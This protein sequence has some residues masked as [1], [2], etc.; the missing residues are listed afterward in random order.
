[1]LLFWNRNGNDNVLPYLFYY[2]P[3]LVFAAIDCIHSSNSECILCLCT[4]ASLQ[5]Y[6]YTDLI[7]LLFLS[8]TNEL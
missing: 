2:T 5:S 4:P 6:N 8:F 3:I 7:I 1:M